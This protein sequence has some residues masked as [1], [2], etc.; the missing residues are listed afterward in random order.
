MNDT[1]ESQLANFRR[2]PI[3]ASL[4]TIRSVEKDLAA[5]F[6]ADYIA[7]MQESNGGEG[8]VGSEGYLQLWAIE[9]LVEQNKAYETLVHFPGFVFLG[10][11]G[12]G[13]AIALGNTADGSELFLM[14]FIGDINDGLFGGRSFLEF[15]SEYGNGTIWKRE[16]R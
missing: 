9:T 2:A 12:A 13:D 6:P 7:F 10:S 14:P 1:F 11:N 5:R 8:E 16:R 15:L 4:E 3:G